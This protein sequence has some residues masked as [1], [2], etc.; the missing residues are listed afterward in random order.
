MFRRAS[1]LAVLLAATLVGSRPARGDEDARTAMTFLQGLRDRGYFDLALEYLE[2]LRAQKTTPDEIRL[3][4]DY[5]EGRL[6]LDEAA[7]TG[8][9]GRRRELLD[10][11]RDKLNAFTKA[12]PNHP[13]AS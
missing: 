4:I 10:E 3:V 5:E 11:A 6:K 12:Q 1:A 7:R 13:Q 8:D 2:K 9:L